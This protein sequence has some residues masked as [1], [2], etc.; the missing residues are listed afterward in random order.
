MSVFSFGEV[1]QERGY[2]VLDE[3][4]M[5][6]SAGVMLLLA[7]IAFI[8]GFIL[9]NYIAIPLLVGFMAL[10]FAI[11]LFINPRFSPTVLIARL[12]TWR[13]SDLP[14]GAIQKKFAWSL[15]LFLTTTIFV[16]SFFLLKNDAFFDPVCMLCVLCLLFLYLESAF[17]ICV[18][19]QIYHL[20]LRWKLIKAPEVAPNCM[21]DSC[22]IS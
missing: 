19:C 13:Q 15:G 6:G 1:S 11:G 16:L 20:A 3:R 10:N 2:K 12:M 14:I 4:T 18:G 22:E 21:G 17:G 7:V 5:R 9:K 8:N